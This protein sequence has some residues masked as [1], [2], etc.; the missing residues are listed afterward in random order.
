MLVNIIYIYYGFEDDILKYLLWGDMI[1]CVMLF[2]FENRGW[3][4]ILEFFFLLI[5]GYIF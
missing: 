3:F 1:E 2:D 5:K 4:N